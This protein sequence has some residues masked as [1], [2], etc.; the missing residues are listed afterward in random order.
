MTDREIIQGLIDRDH[1]ITEHFIYNKCRPLLTAIMRLVFNHPVE[2]NEMV[3]EL[4]DYLMEDDCIKLRQFQ[5]RSTIYQW[6]KVVATRFFIH[7]RDLLIE[8]VPEETL[9]EKHNDD[10]MVDTAQMVAQEIDVDRLL[11]LMENQRYADVVRHLILRDEEPE[12]YAESIGV[13]VD[14]LYNIKKRAIA[15]LSRIAIKYYSYG[16]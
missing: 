12:K 4:Y 15:A 1:R 6:M 13:T 2:Y 9:Y 7:K 8:N 10:E 5:Y 3:S 14:N 16:R 11:S